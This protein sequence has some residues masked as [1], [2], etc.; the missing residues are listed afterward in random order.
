M[1]PGDSRQANPDGLSLEENSGPIASV[2]DD[3]NITLSQDFEIP[4]WY[5]LGQS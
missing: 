5:V 1:A 3:V 4:K 2:A